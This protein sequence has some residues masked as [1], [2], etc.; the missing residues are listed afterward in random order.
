MNDQS[1]GSALEE[2][3]DAHTPESSAVS[4]GAGDGDASTEGKR[5]GI[6]RRMYDWVL[7]WADTPYGTPA[8]GGISFM[9]SSFFP[10][11]PDPLMMALAV[12]KRERS[13]WYATVCTVASVIGGLFGYWI[14]ATFFDA[15]GEKI[16]DFYGKQ[17]AFESLKDCLLFEQCNSHIIPQNDTKYI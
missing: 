13:L 11:P 8:L 3:R 1:E 2:E 7:H 15:F 5:P 4:G 12:S 17:D 10:V 16:I 14:G 9:E 6:M